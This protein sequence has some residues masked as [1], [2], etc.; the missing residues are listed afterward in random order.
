MTTD[1]TDSD[2]T[3]G[4]EAVGV[5]DASD[6][7]DRIAAQ[8]E[9][10]KQTRRR[11][12]LG[13]AGLAVFLVFTTLQAFAATELLNP[14]ARL[15]TFTESLTGFFPITDYFGVLPF[16]DLGQY[17]GFIRQENLL[18]DPEIGGLLF[19]FPPNPT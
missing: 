1:T 7:P 14:D 15:E 8:F 4:P 17:I 12:A 13:W 3:R 19:Q 5:D 6:V 18:Y 16:L 11:R 10:I 9:N 2:G